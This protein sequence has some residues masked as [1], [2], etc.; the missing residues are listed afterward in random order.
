MSL[1]FIQ[2]Y[3]PTTPHL[4]KAGRPACTHQWVSHPLRG[5]I[6]EAGFAFRLHYDRGAWHTR[7]IAPAHL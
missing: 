5:S 4:N 7:L 6:P 1:R 3:Y 2:K